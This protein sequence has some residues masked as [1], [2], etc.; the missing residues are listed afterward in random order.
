MNSRLKLTTAAVLLSG[1]MP[2]SS[3]AMYSTTAQDTYI[4]DYDANH[5]FGDPN[6]N[7]FAALTLLYHGTACSSQI[8]FKIKNPDGTYPFISS[9]VNRATLYVFVS[10]IYA[11]GTLS[12]DQI[13]AKGVPET[14]PEWNEWTL[15]YNSFNVNYKDLGQPKSIMLAPGNVAWIW[16][17]VDV[18]DYVKSWVPVQKG[19]SPAQP[20]FGI[21]AY[22]SNGATFFYTSKENTGFSHAA[23]IDILLNS[24][25]TGGTGATGATGATGSTGST[26]MTGVTGVTGAT[27]ATGLGITGSTGSTG[28]TG[29]TGVTGAT[30]ITGETGATGVGV[31][32]ATGATGVTGAT[33]P[34]GSASSG[35]SVFNPNGTELTGAKIVTGTTSTIAVSPATVTITFSSLF[36]NTPN[37]TVTAIHNATTAGVVI[38]ITA[39]SASSVTF[40]NTNTINTAPASY[41]CVGN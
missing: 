22:A 26:G 13:I 2:V 27:G 33:G 25:A 11:W 17:A 24:G 28:P 15:T 4:C 12:I 23:Y 8:Q 30:G 14:T 1:L 41:I 7:T 18:T 32:G 10:D 40:Q 37:C 3:S 6:T 16:Y 29:A 9:D 36:N 39:V 20:N 34:T 38:K 19:G 35:T 5:A 31:T 21:H